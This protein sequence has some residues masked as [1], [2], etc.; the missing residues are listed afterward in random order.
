MSKLS[1]IVKNE[2]LTDV[3]SKSFWI[4][5]IVA[6]LAMV[7]FGIF[8]G[9]MMAESD[10]A[11]SI[12]ESM[13]TTPDTE[14][15]TPMKLAGLLLGLFLTIFL[16]MYGS[17]IYNKVRVEKCN[18]IVEILATCVDGKT[19]MLAKIIAAGLT[20]LTQMAL[21][22]LII[23]AVVSGIVIVFS[24]DI[25]FGFLTQRWIWEA[26]IW[27]VIFFIGGY[28]FFGSLYAACG[29]MTDKDNENQT[30]MT[31]LTLLLFGSLYIGQYAV[32]HGDNIF[33]V[34]CSYIPFTAATTAS[35][36]AVTGAAPL[37]QTITAVITLYI[38]AALA[39]MLSGKI[40]SCSLLLKGKN[41]TPKDIMTFL[42]SR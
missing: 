25:S 28:I 38:F 32:D 14:E 3:R 24:P 6:P 13:P 22:G 33:A 10:S 5:T 30:Y 23:A 9:V 31:V 1:L 35:V 8:G 18:R 4:S 17:M 40:Y 27:A 11:N 12:M 39:L 42:R 16:T 26:L 29:A 7:A 21:W 36:N 37:W 20:G 2:Y 15:M 41:F 34:I 19:M